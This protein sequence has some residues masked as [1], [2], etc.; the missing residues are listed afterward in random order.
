MTYVLCFE[1][2]DLQNYLCFAKLSQMRSSHV[3]HLKYFENCP[4]WEARW[5]VILN[6]SKLVPVAGLRCGPNMN[7]EGDVFYWGLFCD[8]SYFDM[9]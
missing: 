4:N 5:Q 1:A 7:V 9:T 6:F 8:L 3:S 2:N